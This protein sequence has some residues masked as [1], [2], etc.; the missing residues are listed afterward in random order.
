MLRKPNKNR[1]GI[2]R[3]NEDI[4]SPEV[5][6]LDESGGNLGV[7]KTRDAVTKAR[8][9]NLDVVEISA[10]A[11][12]PVAQMMDYGKYQYEQNKLRKDRFESTKL[13]SRKSETKMTQIKPNTSKDILDMRAKKSRQWLDEGYRV[14]INLFLRGREKGMDEGVLKSKLS[15]FTELIPEPYAIIENIRKSPKGYSILIQ[16]SK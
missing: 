16:P 13:A 15:Q 10:A 3:I 2:I 8:S 1:K 14:Q 4:K 9:I 12:P 7:V 5:R 6:L 11:T